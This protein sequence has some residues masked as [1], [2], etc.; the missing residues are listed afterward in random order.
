MIIIIISFIFSKIQRC[1]ISKNSPK[2]KSNNSTLITKTW[3]TKHTKTLTLYTHCHPKLLVVKPHSISEQ[4]VMSP[5]VNQ[6][7][8][9]PFPVLILSDSEKR[10]SEISQSD[11]VMLILKSTN[12]QNVLNLNVINH[13]QVK[14][15]IHQNV[16]TKVAL[17]LYNF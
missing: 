2:S 4:S 11:L 17:K 9:E 10:E 12:V 13:F 8:S 7:L 1:K 6:Q 14:K 3:S 16:Q 15:K 5:M